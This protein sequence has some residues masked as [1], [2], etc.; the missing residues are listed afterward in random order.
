MDEEKNQESKTRGSNWEDHFAAMIKEM[1]TD[2]KDWGKDFPT[3]EFRDHTRAARREMLLAFRSLI[4]T[5]L[6]KMDR[7]DPPEP[8]ASRI[9]IE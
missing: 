2:S 8:K 4:D 7:E 6:E 9:T 5:A 1:R 3:K